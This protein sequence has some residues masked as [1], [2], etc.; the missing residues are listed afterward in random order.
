MSSRRLT[1]KQILRRV[2]LQRLETAHTAG[3]GPVSL[4]VAMARQHGWSIQQIDRA[5][6]ELG[7]ISRRY[8]D[9][10]HRRGPVAGCPCETCDRR[11]PDHQLAEPSARRRRE[12]WRRRGIH[13]REGSR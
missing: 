1:T 11:T 7:K 4:D 5:L 6:D 3:V 12:L 2:M 8:G 10:A 9:L 13:L